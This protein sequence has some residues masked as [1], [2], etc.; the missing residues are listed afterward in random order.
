VSQWNDKSGNNYH[1]TQSTSTNRPSYVS[2]P[3]GLNVLRFGGNSARHFL[4]G[5]STMPIGLNDVAVFAVVRFDT[6][7]VNQSSYIFAKSQYETNPNRLFFGLGTMGMSAGTFDYSVPP[8]EPNYFQYHIV[9]FVTDRNGTG[10]TTGYSNGTQ[11]FQRTNPVDTTNNWDNTA[12]WLIIGGYNQSSG[13]YLPP[14]EGLY[15]FGDICELIVYASTIDST[16]R[17]QVEGYLAWKWGLQSN[18]PSN[19]PYSS[20]AVPLG[21][22]GSNTF[23]VQ[24]NNTNQYATGYNNITYTNNTRQVT[25][26]A[27]LSHYLSLP[28]YTMLSGYSGNTYSFWMNPSSVQLGALV[29]ITNPTKGVKIILNTDGYL[30]F[31]GNGITFSNFCKYYANLINIWTHVVIVATQSDLAI[32]YNGVRQTWEYVNQT[33]SDYRLPS[34]VYPTFY[35]GRSYVGEYFNGGLRDFRYFDSGLSQSEVTSLYA[36]S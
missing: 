25:F 14:A 5:G 21:L 6:R 27:S 10:T 15:M 8:N 16:K 35:I 32:Y 12:N 17:Q 31:Y 7:A 36:S 2:G 4:G 23:V 11:F 34:G 29:L 9:E 19:H 30:Y 22:S 3:N 13:G 33:S 1:F 26:N 28:T 24:Y 20:T 18:L